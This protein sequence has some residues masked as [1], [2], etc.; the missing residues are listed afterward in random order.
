MTCRVLVRSNAGPKLGPGKVGDYR[1]LLTARL[2][3]VIHTL[4]LL[5]TSFRHSLVCLLSSLT[6]SCYRVLKGHEFIPIHDV[7][8]HFLSSGL[9]A[10]TWTD[11]WRSTRSQRPTFT[12]KAGGPRGCIHHSRV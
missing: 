8:P 4:V 2:T 12:S 9:F 10:K 1:E 3:L 6:G 7:T 11:R 5:S